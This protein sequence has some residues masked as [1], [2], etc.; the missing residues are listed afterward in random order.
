MTYNYDISTLVEKTEILKYQIAEYNDPLDYMR[1]YPIYLHP[2]HLFGLRP[3]M[4]LLSGRFNYNLRNVN[5]EQK[6]S[7]TFAINKLNCHWINIVD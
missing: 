6:R 1:A 7:N 3:R 2:I 4:Y 5:Y